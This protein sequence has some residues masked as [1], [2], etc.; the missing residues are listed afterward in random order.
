M[1]RTRRR[2]GG[3]T[4]VLLALVLGIIMIIAALVIDVG[5]THRVR[6]ETHYVCDA[7]SLAGIAEW[8]ASRD[9]GM[10]RARALEICRRNG[11]VVG[12]NGVTHIRAYGY[13][14]ATYNPATG[15]PI[16][17]PN[18]DR[19]YVE[20]ARELPQYIA[21]IIGIG[22]T[23]VFLRAVSALLGSVPIDVSFGQMGFPDR[24]NLAQFG[25][26]APFTFGDP[27]STR[28]LDNGQP[29]EL[30]NPLGYRYDLYIPPDVPNGIVRIEIFDPDTINDPAKIAGGRHVVKNPSRLQDTNEANDPANGLPTE[31]ELGGLD[32]IRRPPPNGNG[33]TA[34]GADFVA[35]STQTEWTIVDGA[36]NTIARATYGPRENTPFYLHREDCTGPPHT[37][38]DSG[39]G[40]A[41][42]ATDP[43]RKSVV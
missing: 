24:A 26:D 13:N 32:E 20:I 41:Q 11:Y 15:A 29:N 2:L 38:V 25:P 39:N 23:G 34:P 27:Y 31:P 21:N 8:V 1:R 6:A 18:I 3:Q 19:Y 35:N 7:A 42:L 10:A 43:D 5:A 9:A 33:D 14:H 36:G 40:M 30:Y 4:I 28:R 17:P 22:R 12:Q 16:D 37:A